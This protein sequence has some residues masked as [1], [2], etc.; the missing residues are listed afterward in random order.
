MTQ[1][2]PK[3][4]RF[5]TSTT[6]RSHEDVWSDQRLARRTRS[7]DLA[8]WLDVVQADLDSYLFG[9][10]LRELRDVLKVF[11]DSSEARSLLTEVERQ[12]NVR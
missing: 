12:R 4:D 10:A 5:V 2:L 7:Q 3:L 1:S 6:F 8:S 9:E 11:P